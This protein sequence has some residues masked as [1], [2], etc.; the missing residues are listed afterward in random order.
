MKKV[1]FADEVDVK[2]ID[3]NRNVNN[4]DNLPDNFKNEINYFNNWKIKLFSIFFIFLII[5]LFING[6]KF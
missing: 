5:Y 2:Y 4:Y 6:K 1:T 3:N